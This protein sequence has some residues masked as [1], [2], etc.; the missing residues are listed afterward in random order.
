[1][2]HRPDVV[3]VRVR[4]PRALHTAATSAAHERERT[5]SAEIRLALRRQLDVYHAPQDTGGTGTKGGG[6]A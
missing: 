3:T 2:P 1:V 5:L 4:I 6:R